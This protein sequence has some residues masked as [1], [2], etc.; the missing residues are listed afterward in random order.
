MN[1]TGQ[2]IKALIAITA[3][4]LVSACM[5]QSA[6]IQV[7]DKPNSAI[8]ENLEAT[9]NSMPILSA[10]G[11]NANVFCAD[12][13]YPVGK[14]F[15]NKCNRVGT[16][17]AMSSVF[18]TGSVGRSGDIH[19]LEL[20]KDLNGKD[21]IIASAAA[22][23][24][25][26]FPATSVI[27]W[28]EDGIIFEAYQYGTQPTD[29]LNSFSVGK[30]LVGQ[31]VGVAIAEGKISS[32]QDKLSKYIP[33][34]ASTGWA[35]VTV[36]DLVTMQSGISYK[37]NVDLDMLY[38]N[39]NR[40]EE[41]LKYSDAK[42]PPGEDFFYNEFNTIALV[43]ILEKVYSKP[44]TSIASQKIWSKIGAQKSA[45][46]VANNQGN[47][48]PHGFFNA[49]ARDYLRWGL[50]MLNGGQ[51]HRGQQVVPTDWIL[52]TNGQGALK[53]ECP[54][55]RGCAGS[56]WGYSY[57]SWLLPAN[58]SVAFMGMYGQSVIASPTKKVVVVVTGVSD[59]NLLQT[60]SGRRLVSALN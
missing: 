9:A 25:K 20:K 22:D 37:S 8:S 6:N 26:S 29:L 28:R 55:R 3:I 16:F 14:D 4:F 47:Y 50:L 15:N 1:I 41:L 7:K 38:K 12:K 10:T 36:Y 59:S 57:H 43:E 27:V 21:Q 31:L 60:V 18:K 34:T 49:T 19:K 44:I 32:A 45:Q 53:G 56:G 17:R 48:L 24:I 11:P 54:F 35:D 51:N 42:Q 5:E 40:L 23:F 58:E 46:I 39:K 52:E 13:G 2:N 33:Q 30:S